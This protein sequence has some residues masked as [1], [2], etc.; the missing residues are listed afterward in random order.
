AQKKDEDDHEIAALKNQVS[1]RFIEENFFEHKYKDAS[2]KMSREVLMTRNGSSVLVMGFMGKKARMLTQ[3]FER[4]KLKR[5][6]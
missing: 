5:I 2:G 3:Y 1:L 6:A 4:S